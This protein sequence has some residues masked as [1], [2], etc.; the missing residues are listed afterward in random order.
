METGQMTLK[1]MVEASYPLEDGLAAFGH[2]AAM[3][4]LVG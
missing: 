2:A 4:V 3:K 1:P